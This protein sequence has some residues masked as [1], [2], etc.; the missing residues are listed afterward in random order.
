MNSYD[1]ETAPD[2]QEWLAHDHS[3][4]IH[5]VEESHRR[6]RNRHP[7]PKLHSLITVIVEN[8]IA[9]ALE[10]VVRAVA[11]LTAEGLSRHEAVHALGSVVITHLHDVVHGQVPAIA[12]KATYLAAVDELTKRKW[13]GR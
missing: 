11:R 5:F 3:D 6:G 10:P 9:E 4:R 13:L 12:S 8:Q 2:A 7:Q 1:P